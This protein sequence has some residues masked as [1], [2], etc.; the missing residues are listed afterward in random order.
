MIITVTQNIPQTPEV[1]SV[2]LRIVPTITTPMLMAGEVNMIGVPGP[3]G[4]PGPA[5]TIVHVG[6]TAPPSP[7]VNDLWVDTT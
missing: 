1:Q 6:S 5:G 2:G 7:N 4:P 3:Q